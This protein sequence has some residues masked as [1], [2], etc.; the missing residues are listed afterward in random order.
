MRARN[1]T[2]M[3]HDMGSRGI[4]QGGLYAPAMTYPEQ[5]GQNEKRCEG[6][7]DLADDDGEAS[8]ALFGQGEDEADMSAWSANDRA[9]KYKRDRKTNGGFV[10]TAPRGLRGPL[11]R[12]HFCEGQGAE[13]VGKSGGKGRKRKPAWN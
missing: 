13:F 6:D 12:R 9:E 7:G 11:R 4:W 2:F 5:G 8:A 10:D 1:Q 3:T